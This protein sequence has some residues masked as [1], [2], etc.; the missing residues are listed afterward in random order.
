M[1]INYLATLLQAELA[2]GFFREKTWLWKTCSKI[3]SKVGK[4]QAR[5]F[6]PPPFSSKNSA[7][8]FLG[9][10]CFAVK[11]NSSLTDVT[12]SSFKQG[13]RRIPA[14]ARFLNSS[15]EIQKRQKNVFIL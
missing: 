5:K 11:W 15:S 13:K 8:I 9:A 14:R 3:A 2:S 4:S 7:G 10:L 12:H 1:S 6:P